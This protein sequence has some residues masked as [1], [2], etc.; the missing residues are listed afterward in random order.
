M[1]LFAVIARG[2]AE[3]DGEYE[4]PF[5]RL[6]EAPIDVTSRPRDDSRLCF[7]K[8]KVSQDEDC[9]ATVA[10]TEGE[11]DQSPWRT[12]QLCLSSAGS[13]SAQLPLSRM[14]HVQVAHLPLEPL[15]AA[16]EQAHPLNLALIVLTQACSL[17]CS[18]L[19]NASSFGITLRCSHAQVILR[20][21]DRKR[22]PRGL[23]ERVEPRRRG[24]VPVL[25]LHPGGPARR[26]A[27]RTMSV[28]KIIERER[29][30]G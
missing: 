29:D 28:M 4:G 14:P 3:F 5:S 16:F 11:K 21:L 2:I 23:L 19:L 7:S 17:A 10:E 1:L 20:C 27:A 18:L 6:W 30:E 9:P 25:D 15:L 22:R 26:H 12:A 13:T 24:H 8:L